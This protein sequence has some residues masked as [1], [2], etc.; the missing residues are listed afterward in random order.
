MDKI[1]QIKKA[2]QEYD[3]D[4][5][6]E[7]YVLVNTIKD[8]VNYKK[9]EYLWELWG[10]SGSVFATNYEE[11]KELIIKELDIQERDK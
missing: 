8:I 9:K 5:R 6:M 3:E 2:I 1:E 11:A 4:V 10:Y 7:A